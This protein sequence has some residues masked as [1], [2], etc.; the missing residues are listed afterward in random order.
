MKSHL[1]FQRKTRKER[2]EALTDM[3]QMNCALTVKIKKNKKKKRKKLSFFG[4]TQ[5]LAHHTWAEV[6]TVAEIILS[7]I[8]NRKGQSHLLDLEAMPP[9]IR[10]LENTGTNTVRMIL[11]LGTQ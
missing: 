5:R 8:L 10:R 11:D 3:L 6:S 2:G 1:C 7:L 4:E 9:R